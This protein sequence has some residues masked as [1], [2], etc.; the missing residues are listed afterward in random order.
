[1]T[2]KEWEPDVSIGSMGAAELE[3]RVGRGVGR[4][5]GRVAMQALNT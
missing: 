3:G 1:M 4:G 5:V 2:E